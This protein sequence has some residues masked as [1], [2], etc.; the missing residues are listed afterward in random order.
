MKRRPLPNPWTPAERKVLDR[1]RTPGDV[2]RLLETTA[3]SSE[4]IY[5]SPRS[6]LRDGKA[7]CFDGAMLAAAALE[8]QGYEPLLVDLRAHRDDDHVLAVYRTAGGW[9][10]VAKSNFVG[11]R[12]RAPV[13]RTMRELAM[14]YFESYFNLERRPSLRSVSPPL[15]LRAF[16]RLEWRIND[17]AMDTIAARLDASPHAPLLSAAAAR[18]LD[19]IDQRTWDGHTVG[20]DFAGAYDPRKK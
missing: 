11:L 17:R 10:A 15:K 13:Y 2:Q 20:T 8:R 5:R 16:E 1:L 6:V 18:R 19:D 12:G 7:H 9:G 4:P 3:Y 14:S